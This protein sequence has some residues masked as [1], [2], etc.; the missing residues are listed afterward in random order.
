VLIEDITILIAE[1]EEELRE[2]LGEFIGLFFKHVI[3]AKCGHDAYMRYLDKRPDI[4]LTDINMPNLDGLSMIERIRERDNKTNIIIMSAHSDREK[5]LRAIK[6]QLV[7]YLVKPIKTDELKKILFDIVDNIRAKAT[8]IY[9]GNN[10]FWDK[11]NRILISHE[12]ELVLNERELML[13]ELLCSKLNHAFSSENIFYHLFANQSEKEFSQYAITSLIKRLRSK[14]P[15]N[16]IQSEYG[17][18]YKI[19]KKSQL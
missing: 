10:T 1:D 2:Y 18:G 7:T 16:L 14:L 9:L 3:L 12:K 15:E 13:I 6:L 5:L 11:K 17:T 8:R 19:V 4:I